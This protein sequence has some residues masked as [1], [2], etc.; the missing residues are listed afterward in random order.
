M[1]E[2]T[3]SRFQKKVVLLTNSQGTS[4]GVHLEEAYPAQLS[5]CLAHQVDIHRISI[6]G[7]STVNFVEILDDNVIVLRPDIVIVQTG[8]VECAQRILSDSEK[9]ILRFVLFGSSLT[10]W[11]HQHR[12][13]VLRIRQ[14]IGMT[15]RSLKPSASASHVDAI[16]Q[17]LR[18]A[19][20]K[21]A[22]IEVLKFS[23][24]GIDL[25]HP[26]INDDIDAYNAVLR[27]YDSI[28]VDAIVE[29]LGAR[30]YQPNSVHFTIEGH[31]AIASAL[32]VE[33]AKRLK[34]LKPA[35]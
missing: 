3:L 19:G 7:W 34:C 18:D 13:S 32:A 9:K 20:I 1:S 11:M 22:F 30:L 12:A 33:V 17:K 4:T 6:G 26:F 8:I 25:R 24:G 16:H 27:Q 15:T 10:K 31:K 28:S 21:C 2:Q 5:R 29:E 23:D 35:G 14:R